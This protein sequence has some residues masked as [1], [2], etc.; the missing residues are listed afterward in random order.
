MHA[1]RPD[2]TRGSELGAEP[3]PSRVGTATRCPESRYAGSGH[4]RRQSSG[5]GPQ[6]PANQGRAAN[7]GAPRF[8][9]PLQS[10]PGTRT[11]GPTSCLLRA[12]RRRGTGSVVWSSPL[13]GR[14]W[15]L[16]ELDWLRRPWR[17]ERALTLRSL[18]T[19]PP[20]TGSK[21]L[22]VPACSCEAEGRANGDPARLLSSLLGTP[23]QL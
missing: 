3:S 5:A 8:G 10:E 20:G 21:V 16:G 11:L 23:R 4:W 15:C 9:P 6:L 14:R 1:S 19:A 17:R 7:P 13:A 18:P 2:P 12:V 22:R